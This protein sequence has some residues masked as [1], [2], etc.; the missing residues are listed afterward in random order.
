MS[1]GVVL[2][3]NLA[4]IRLPTLLMSLYRD[5]ET[6]VLTLED[7]RFKKALYIKEGMVVYATTTDP[8]ERFGEAMLRRGSITLQQYEDSLDYVAQGRQ[9]GRA[10]VDMGALTPMELV[11]GVT[12]QLYDIIHSLFEYRTGT[13]TLELAPFSTREMITLGLEIPAVIFRGMCRQT[14]WSQMRPMVGNP[15]L[16]LRT[17][18]S[19]PPYLSD[20]DLNADQEHVLRICRE[21]L[22]V[23]S[24]LEASYL[25]QFE[26]LR[27]LWVFL[28]LG[29]MEREDPAHRAKP[30]AALEPEALVE[31]YNDVYAFIHHH[32]SGAGV[33]A[34]ELQ[35]LMESLAQASPVL[36]ANQS[37]LARFGRLDV[38]AVLFSLRAI[39]EAQRPQA[40]QGFLEE[41]LYA[42]ALEADRRLPA[43]RRGAVRDYIR[44]QAGSGEER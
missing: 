27:L 23:T 20:L 43:D 5:R 9:Q 24:I 39:P 15:A 13:Y 7:D 35:P 3:G 19:P 37:D 16:R 44:R 14:A 32:L 34:E 26:T 30:D 38:D 4:E 18:T 42:L 25:P 2:S 33:G 6:G 8:D 22:P 29:L 21:G 10:L 36:A 11:E 31:Q 41:A 28:T 12:Q 40:L 17:C 1:D